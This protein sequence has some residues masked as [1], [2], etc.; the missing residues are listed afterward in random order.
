MCTRKGYATSVSQLALATAV[1]Y[2]P[3]S[4]P[5]PGDKRSAA[6]PPTIYSEFPLRIIAQPFEKIQENLG[7]GRKALSLLFR[8]HYLSSGISS[9]GIRFKG[10]SW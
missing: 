7:E 6:Q 1:L 4:I 2:F 3:L 8:I 5:Q 10:I 9:M